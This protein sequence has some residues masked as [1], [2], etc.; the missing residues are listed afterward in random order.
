MSLRKKLADTGVVHG[1]DQLFFAALDHIPLSAERQ[2]QLLLDK[3]V[4]TRV[5]GSL[6]Q[7]WFVEFEGSTQ[8][9]EVFVHLEREVVGPFS[10]SLGTPL[11]QLEKGDEASR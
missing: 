9:K 7:L 11:G 2:G 3:R 4:R 1:A 5:K 6:D 8:S 10:R